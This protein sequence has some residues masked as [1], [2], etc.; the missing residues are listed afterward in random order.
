MVEQDPPEQARYVVTA[1][2]RGL[3]ILSMFR[4]DR[5]V[6]SVPEITAELGVPRATAFRMAYT[7]ER[8]GYLIRLPNS[9][10]F[11]LGPKVL[12]L[13]FDYMHTTEV[14]AC[15]RDMVYAVRDRTGFSTHLCVR[16][17][18]DIVYV[19]SAS[20]HHPLRG[21]IPVG[22][23]YPCHAVASGRALLFD[24]TGPELSALYR[25]VP[26]QIYSEQTPATVEALCDLLAAER[27]QGYAVN[28]SSFVSGIIS[29]SVPV[30]DKDGTIVASFNVSDSD[31]VIKDL[32]LVRAAVLQAA[33]QISAQLGWRGP[34]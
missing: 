25:D 19:L 21:D 20:S 12:L 28:I 29:M 13:G 3:A 26:L 33:A 34:L 14:V 30:R 10:A 18:T 15:A 2:R 32:D 31:T 6:V 9:H 4:R 24:M 8:D 11:Q 7:L 22:A 17:G 27:A 1:L 16:D 5:R 23:R